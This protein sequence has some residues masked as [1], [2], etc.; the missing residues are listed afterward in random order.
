M[1]L[2]PGPGCHGAG[3]RRL[4]HARSPGQDGGCRGWH[5]AWADVRAVMRWRGAVSHLPP[6]KATIVDTP[7]F[8]V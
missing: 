8:G 7:L 4:P 5:V 3:V 1:P 6:A 2:R